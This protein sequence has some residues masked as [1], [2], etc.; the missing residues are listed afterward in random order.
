MSSILSILRHNFP[1]SAT[2]SGVG[3]G[4]RDHGS[5]VVSPADHGWS[6]RGAVGARLYADLISDFYQRVARAIAQ[7]EGEI[8]TIR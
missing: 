6:R 1:L 5:G 8:A 3:G 4:G 2:G 7:P